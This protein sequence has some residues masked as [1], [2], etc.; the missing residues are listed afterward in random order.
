MRLWCHFTGESLGGYAL[1]DLDSPKATT[2]GQV[3]WSVDGGYSVAT[4]SGE[5]IVEAKRNR[6]DA[7]AAYTAWLEAAGYETEQDIGATKVCC[8]CGWEKPLLDFPVSVKSMDRRNSMCE[9]CIEAGED[10][11]APLDWKQRREQQA[12]AWARARREGRAV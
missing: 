7:V 11:P 1:N 10:R 12:Q 5:V 6:D 3:T 9:A 2:V 4:T 8:W